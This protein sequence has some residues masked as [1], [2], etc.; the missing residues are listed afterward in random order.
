MSEMIASNIL[1]GLI[2]G[3]FACWLFPN[4]LFD[5]RWWALVVLLDATGSYLI[6]S[7]RSI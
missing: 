7:I 1:L 3:I 5:W 6:R 4:S 2:V